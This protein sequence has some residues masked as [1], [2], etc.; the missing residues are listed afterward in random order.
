MFAFARELVNGRIPA[1]RAYKVDRAID[2]D[3]MNCKP[4]DFPLSPSLYKPSRTLLPA[5]PLQGLC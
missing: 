1:K 3:A 5:M 2:F 4:A